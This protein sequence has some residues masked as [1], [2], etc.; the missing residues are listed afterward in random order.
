MANGVRVRIGDPNVTLGRGRH[1][2]EIRYRTARQLG[3]F[4]DR[5]ELYWNVNGTGWAFA[6][7]RLSAEVRLPQR[8]P[9]AQLR[10]EAYTGPQGARGRAY[11]AISED[12]GAAFRATRRLAPNEG[13]TIVVGF[14]KGIVSAPSASQ[15]VRWWLRDNAGLAAG[16]GGA[17]LLIGFLAWRWREVGRD[18][19][20]GPRFPRYQ[21]PAGLGPAGV[22]YVDRMKFDDR[23][24]TAALLGLGERGF[25]KIRQRGERYEVD[26]TG[27]SVEWLPGEQALANELFAG[28][29]AVEIAREHDT[30]VQFARSGLRDAI[31]KHFGETL[32]AR[33]R[34][35]LAAGFLVAGL[36]LT[37][38]IVD[39]TA[40]PLIALVGA[41]IVATLALFARWLP[42]YSDKGRA[43][44]DEI[45]GLRQYLSVAE[46]DELARM[47]APPQ[48]REEFSKFLPYAHAL[49]VERNWTE[50]FGATLGAAAVAAAVAE[51]YLASA[52]SEGDALRSLT[53]S[54]SD[55][56]GTVAAAS[57]PPGSSSGGSDSGGGG[58]SSGGGGGGG[59]GG[60]W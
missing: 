48:T 55:L 51:Y 42:A 45:E 31:V 1:E 41:V 26:R 9:A 30:K 23:C 52:G 58:G 27:K 47:K 38:M 21:A 12:G 17:L 10:L 39:D 2:Y 46:A 16:A 32:F 54:M 60:G 6:F 44:K 5:D 19:R 13:M 24:F 35:S 49:G 57:T 18:P 50:R 3:F 14:P 22:R 34:G 43:L 33:N 29:S 40:L 8:T 7:D 15:K 56:G 28:R 20:A 53:D 36:A 4:R 59:G 11:E 37:A 25:L